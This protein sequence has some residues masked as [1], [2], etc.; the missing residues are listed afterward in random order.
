MIKVILDIVIIMKNARHQLVS[1]FLDHEVW[2]KEA[3]L[4]AAFE[5]GE[6]AA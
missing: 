2:S 3:A 6:E 5:A 4:Q 1:D